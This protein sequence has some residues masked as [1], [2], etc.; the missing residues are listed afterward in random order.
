MSDEPNRPSPLD[1]AAT[2]E[3]QP[4]SGSGRWL[5]AAVVA[6]L[7]V[8]PAARWLLGRGG[9]ASPTAARPAGSA[10]QSPLQSSFQ[11]YQAKRYDEAIAAAKTALASDPS[12]A[13]AYN[14]LAVS[15]LGVRRYD[16]AIEA[17]QNAIRLRPD[18]QLAKNNL[19]WIQQER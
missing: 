10:A 1:T 17:A 18:F 11:A 3:S 7:V 5:I 19:A 2:D 6:L 4:R 9:A 14:N 12:S 16:E 13:D 15:Y 8:Y